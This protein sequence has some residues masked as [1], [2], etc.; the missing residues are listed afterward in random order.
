MSENMRRL[1][2]RLQ[3]EHRLSAPE[4]R[5]LLDELDTESAAYAASLASAQC[6]AIYGKRVF[7]RGLLEISNY[8]KNDCLY[9]GIRHSNKNCARYRLTEDEILHCAELG[10]RLGFR[11]FVLQGG[12]DAFYTDQRLCDLIRV[13]KFRYPSCAVTLSLGERSFSSYAALR[14]AGADRYLLRHETATKSHYD[15]LHPTSMSFD[16]RMECLQRLRRLGYAAGCGFMVGSPGQTTAHLA[17][18]LDFIQTFRPQMVGIGPFIPHKDTPFR[19]KP[20]GS[21]QM[22]LFLLSLVRLILPAVLL[23][24]TTALGSIHPKGREMGILAGAN[25]V[26]PNL[27]P[28]YARKQYTLYDNKI[29]GGAEAAENLQKLRARM[30]DIGYSIPIDRGDHAQCCNNTQTHTCPQCRE[31]HTYGSL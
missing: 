8:C 25:V 15:S 2:T 12:E 7:I 18:D 13:L 5:Q 16:N 23:P 19:D 14:Q 28:L 9:C 6:Q 21:L 11:T 17:A 30:A 3:Q 24:S 29:C 1:L 10:Y 27:S 4:Y 20:A 31:E 26:M 22:T